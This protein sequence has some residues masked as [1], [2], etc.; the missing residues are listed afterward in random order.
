MLDMGWNE[1]NRRAALRMVGEIREK[2]RHGLFDPADYFPEYSGLET[3]SAP[4]NPCTFGDYAKVWL[5]SLGQKAPATRDDYQKALDRVWLDQL[6]ERP[7]RSIRYSELMTLIGNLAVAGKTLNNYLIPLRGVFEFARRDGA[8][9][10]NPAAAIE[11]APVQ[12]PAPDPFTLPEVEAILDNLAEREDTQVVNYFAAAFFA[13][14]RPSEQIALRWSDVDF[15]QRAVRVQRAVVRGQAKSS[16]KTYL[17]R[18]VELSDRAW[19]AF[20][21]QRALTQLAGK[22]IFWNPATGAPWADIQSQLRIWQRCVKRLGLRY[23]EPYQAR[24]TFAT[25]ALMAGANPSYIARQLGHTNANMLFRVYS[26]WIDGADKS[27]EREK[28]NVGFGHDLA[29][30]LIAEANK[31]AQSTSYLAETQGFEPWMQLFGRML[32]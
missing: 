28:L 16:T 27:R 23:R 25:L 21:A 14:F 12:K 19:A 7:I 15:G 24:H 3:L 2:I 31:F 22:E 30:E 11:N 8:I 6:G 17:V 9:A 20:E 4:S 13:G 1:R 29:T 10:S 32:P 26:K 18:D 5:R